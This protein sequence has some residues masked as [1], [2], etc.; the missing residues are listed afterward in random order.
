MIRS[1]KLS[2]RSAAALLGVAAITVALV[3]HHMRRLDAQEAA[4]S[5]ITK[6]GGTILVYDEGVYV[7]FPT[8]GT[9]IGLCGTGLI[10]TIGPQG[11]PTDFGDKHIHHFE[12]V[13][14]LLTIDV[15]NTSVTV[16]GVSQLQE[17]LPHTQVTK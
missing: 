17:V 12:A 9:T 13:I 14:D 6:R 7:S 3:G 1:W 4:F 5:E 10:R 16:A 11:V 15:R 8:P 2:I